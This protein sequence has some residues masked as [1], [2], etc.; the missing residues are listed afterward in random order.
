MINCLL[1]YHSKA[2]NMTIWS[3]YSIKS[4]FNSKIDIKKMT[5]KV[6][7]PQNLGDK[8]LW[9]QPKVKYLRLFLYIYIYIYIYVCM[10]VCIID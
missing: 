8:I 3:K 10:Y 7:K 6:V 2:I 1:L 9:S 4:K 5:C